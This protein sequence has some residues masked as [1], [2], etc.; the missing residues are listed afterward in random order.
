MYHEG[1]FNYRDVG[2][3]AH[4]LKRFRFC[5]LIKIVGERPKEY[6]VPDNIAAKFIERFPEFE[7]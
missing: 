4:V 6:V 2:V 7:R 3:N 1:K 5:G